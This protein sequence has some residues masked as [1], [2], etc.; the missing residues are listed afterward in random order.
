[1]QRLVPSVSSGLIRFL[2]LVGRPLSLAREGLLGWEVVELERRWMDCL[3]LRN[4]SD[5]KP[6]YLD[7]EIGKRFCKLGSKSFHNLGYVHIGNKINT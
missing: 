4:V 5:R 2:A 6:P 3:V 1:M 7:K